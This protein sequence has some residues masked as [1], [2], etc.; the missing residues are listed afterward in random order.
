[1]CKCVKTVSAIDPLHTN[2]DLPREDAVLAPVL[3]CNGQHHDYDES[4]QECLIILSLLES[5][6]ETSHPVFL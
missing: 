1:M 5:N 4:N 2:E 3:N 6:L